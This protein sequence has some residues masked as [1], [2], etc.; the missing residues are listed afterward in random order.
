M[1]QTRSHSAHPA[2][3]PARCMARTMCQAMLPAGRGVLST[4]CG[5][6][7]SHRHCFAV[8]EGADLA[9]GV[10][11]D[12]AGKVL[13]PEGPALGRG[14]APR[15]AP[16]PRRLLGAAARACAAGSPATMSAPSGSMGVATAALGGQHRRLRSRRSQSF[17]LATPGQATPMMTMSSRLSWDSP[18]QGRQGLHVAPL[19][20][21]GQPSPCGAISFFARV[22]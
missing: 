3:R 22:R 14:H 19:G 17:S 13:F 1:G 12:A 7:R 11:A 16:A 15:G 8:T 20:D 2:Q 10:A 9:A 18:D 4:A 21:H 6:L 5:R